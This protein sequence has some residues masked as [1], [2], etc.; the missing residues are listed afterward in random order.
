MQILLD[1]AEKTLAIK[2]NFTDLSKELA[3]NANKNAAQAVMSL[4]NE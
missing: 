4:L 2:Q 1:N 3:I